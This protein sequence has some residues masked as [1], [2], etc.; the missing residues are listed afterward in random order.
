M[1]VELHRPTF[2]SAC[3]VGTPAPTIF[4][5]AE[6]R[7]VR[8]LPYAAVRSNSGRTPILASTSSAIRFATA[9]QL[10]RVKRLQPFSLANSRCQNFDQ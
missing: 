10:D 1:F 8:S 6:A 2:T 3:S 9:A 5:S 7:P 4:C